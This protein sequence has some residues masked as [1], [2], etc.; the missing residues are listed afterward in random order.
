[1]KLRYATVAIAAVV[2][3]VAVRSTLV[4]AVSQSAQARSGV[5]TVMGTAF[6]D[7]ET[8]RQGGP[9]LSGA[10]LWLEE[11]DASKSSLVPVG[12]AE[13][14]RVSAPASFDSIAQSDIRTL[15][16]SQ[17]AIDL[18]GAKVGDVFAVRTNEGHLGKLQIVNSVPVGE[19]VASAVPGRAPQGGPFRG[20]LKVKW[21]LWFS[22]FGAKDG[23]QS[24]CQS[25]VN[26]SHTRSQIGRASAN[27]LPPESDY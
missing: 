12:T 8:D 23:A 22:S 1:M 26:P 11:R 2:V 6:W 7:L 4:A 13:L 18:S 27:Y 10:D 24:L 9:K 19:P 5:T 16:Y 14:A 3:V 20:Y 21:F 17:S 25:C 15:R